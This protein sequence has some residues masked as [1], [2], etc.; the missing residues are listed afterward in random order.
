MARIPVLTFFQC[1]FAIL[2]LAGA[3]PVRAQPSLEFKEVPREIRDHA[4]AVRRSCRE[5]DP[6]TTFEDLQGIT[7]V[8]LKG[9]G[10]RDIV[11][12]NKLLC[13]G[14]L[15]GANC[16]NR[17]CDLLIYKE[18]PSGQ[19][20]V[21]FKEHLHERHLAIDWE[22]MRLQL[23]VASIHAGD[24]RCRPNPKKKYSSG[25]SC[26]LIVRYRDNKWNWELIR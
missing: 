20:R 9:D 6:E 4:S 23:M 5:M 18:G 19:W 11:V 7:I 12:D 21:I 17:G 3:A 22:T 1:L 15:K 2:L 8:D 26:N 25:K 10:S 24:P 14:H 13:R 16:S